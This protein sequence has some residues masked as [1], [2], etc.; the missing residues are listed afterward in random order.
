MA[1][2]A[3]ADAP[4]DV[5]VVEVGMGGAW[6]ATNVVDAAVAVVLPIAVDHAQYLGDTP[7]AIAVEKAGI[8]KPGSIAVL[9]QQAPEV[10]RGAARGTRPRSARPWPARAW[11]SASSRGCPPWAGRW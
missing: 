5:A 1:Y 3:F 11:S 10:G 6:D 4:V 2:A 8:I 7:E 9:A